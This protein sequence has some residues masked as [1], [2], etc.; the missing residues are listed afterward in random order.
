MIIKSDKGRLEAR[1]NIKHQRRGKTNSPRDERRPDPTVAETFQS[2]R[3]LDVQMLQRRT[4]PRDALH[5]SKTIKTPSGFQVRRSG[6]NVRFGGIEVSLNVSP[7]A[8]TQILE[9]GRSVFTRS[10][11]RHTKKSRFSPRVI[12]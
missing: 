4:R 6:S 8:S 10:L 12:K 3:T 2:G 5:C 7:P 1:D 9:G 11:I